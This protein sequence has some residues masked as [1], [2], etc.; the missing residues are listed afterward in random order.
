MLVRHSCL[1]RD[2][3]QRTVYEAREAFKRAKSDWMRVKIETSIAD[4]RTQTEGRL[5][6]FAESLEKRREEEVQKN[7]EAL[8]RRLMQRDEDRIAARRVKEAGKVEASVEKLLN[9]LETI[10]QKTEDSVPAAS[11][12]LQLGLQVSKQ[13]GMGKLARRA[14]D[15]PMNLAQR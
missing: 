2:A 12:A 11:M 10:E 7:V 5:Q 3:A 4:L 8:R 1:A 15:K 6:H 14:A 9:R 13:V